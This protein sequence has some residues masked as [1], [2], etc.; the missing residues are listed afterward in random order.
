MNP[1]PVSFSVTARTM[2]RPANEK[3]STL[4][5]GPE[6]YCSAMNRPMVKNE[7]HWRS[8]RARRASTPAQASAACSGPSIRTTPR[9]AV[10]S[11]GLSTNG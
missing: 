5:S 10:A 9:L 3:L 7:P 11:V 6:M 4:Y 8:V 2:C 1:P